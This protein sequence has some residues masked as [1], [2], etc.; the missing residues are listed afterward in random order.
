MRFAAEGFERSSG[1]QPKL[2]QGDA[3]NCVACDGDKAG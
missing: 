1:G 2:V 3:P